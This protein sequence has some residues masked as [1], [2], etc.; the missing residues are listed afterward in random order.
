LWIKK[1]SAISKLRL[2]DEKSMQ[3]QKEA[4]KIPKEILRTLKAHSNTVQ[5][6]KGTKLHMKKNQKNKT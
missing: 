3:F 4:I 1:I 5:K 2:L 6:S